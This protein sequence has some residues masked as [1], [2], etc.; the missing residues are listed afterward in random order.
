MTQLLYVLMAMGVGVG[1]AVQVGLLGQMGRLRGAEEASWISVLGTVTGMA[2]LFTVQS[3][4]NDTPNLPSPFDTLTPFAAIAVLAGAALVVGL[5][6]LDLYFGLAGLFGLFY[7]FG[8][9]FL[10]PRVGI[11]LFVAGVTAGTLIASV[12]LDHFGT[13]GGIVQRVSVVRVAGVVALIVGVL[14]I[15]SG[16]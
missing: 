3:L 10:A 13:F 14:L 15:R 1:S 6:G 7:I 12:G 8:A 5:R 16:R 2:L 9:G 11:A 4:R